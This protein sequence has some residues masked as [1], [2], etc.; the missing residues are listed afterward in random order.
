MPHYATGYGARRPD[1]GDRRCYLCVERRPWW[2]DMVERTADALCWVT[3]NRSC[4]PVCQWAAQL[5]EDRTDRIEFLVSEAD[6]TAFSRWRWGVDPWFSR[7][8]D[9]E[10]SDG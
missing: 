9:E 4:F 10:G 6:A 3:R 5:A 2:T 7:G 8:G 1:G